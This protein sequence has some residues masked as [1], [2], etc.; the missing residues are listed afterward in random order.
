MRIYQ[1]EEEQEE[2]RKIEQNDSQKKINQKPTL[3]LFSVFS[4]C[5]YLCVCV[6]MYLCKG[7]F[8]Y[9]VTRLGGLCS[10]P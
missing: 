4:L 6:F 2:K 9:Y 3:M 8:F 7:A 10:A 5:D 1:W